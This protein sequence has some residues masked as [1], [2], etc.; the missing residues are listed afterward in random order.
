MENSEFAK[1]F[2]E[3]AQLLELRSAGGGEDRFKVRAY[4]KA[5]QNIEDL[6][7][8]LKTVYQK[9]GLKALEEVPGIGAGLAA[10][11]AELI[12]TGRVKKYESLLK[13]FPPGFIEMTRVPGIGPKTALLFLK[14]F[15]I[16]SVAKL[17]QAVAR[18]LIK[19]LPGFK[20]KKL[21]NIRQGLALKEK[22][23][24]RFLLSEADQYIRAIVSQLEKLPEIE[25][26][27]PAGSYRRG[28]ETVGDI[29]L[30]V[31]AG[32]AGPVMKA[33]TSLPQ[34]KRIL[35][36]GPTR[37]SVILKNNM[38][39]DLR[40][41]GPKEFGSAAH[42]F[43]GNKQH[44]IMVREMAIKKGLKISEYG[45]FRKNKWLA[46][47]TEAEVFRSVGLPFIPPELRTGGGELA[48]ARNGRLPRLVELSDIRGDLQMHSDHSDGGNTI[49]ELAGAAKQLGY[50]YI[51][52]TDHTRSARVAGGQTEKE[53]LKELEEID[54]LNAGLKGLRVLKGV[55]IDILPDGTLDY[56][57]EVLKEAEVVIAAVH[58][59]FK[60]PKEKM[61]R[62]LLKAM[63]NKYVNIL[64]HPTGRLIGR[65]D[66]YRVAIEDIIK[67]AKATGTYLEINAYP[68]RLDL[69]DVH[70]RQAK[71]AGVLMAIDT[72][73]HAALQLANMKY[74]VLTAR[75]GWLEKKDIINTL[76]L[77]QLLIKL[78]AKR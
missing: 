2:R 61:T 16:A 25:R 4:R 56:P 54:R 53:F 23:K 73:S 67:A 24:G 39:A 46:G 59:G 57:N 37:A 48:A 33:F 36:R 15:K 77:G 51:A 10:H 75:R 28:Q 29:D 68:E 44:N 9:G 21:E 64:S 65:R 34:V 17:R 43:T 11:I 14:K 38:Q 74:G 31:T 3:I 26:I 40:V 20:E 52:V 66:P 22:A 6:A 19:D 45:V 69:S 71:E 78:K 18:G 55:E 63:E 27:L 1:I 35:S 13:Q 62:R 12:K 72:D 60:M 8:D 50:E 70:C 76:P 47:R 42:Y 32:N 58:S 30:L 7:D 41:V 5:A 49:A